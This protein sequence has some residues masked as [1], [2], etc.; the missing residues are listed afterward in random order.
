MEYQGNSL[1]NKEAKCLHK[2]PAFFALLLQVVGF[3]TP[4]WMIMN[5]DTRS[6]ISFG[7]WYYVGCGNDG[8]ETVT[9]VNF[10]SGKA[11]YMSTLNSSSGVLV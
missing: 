4:G 8:C 2:A 1:L 11:N 5:V 9:L 3:V 10:K 7:I 6:R